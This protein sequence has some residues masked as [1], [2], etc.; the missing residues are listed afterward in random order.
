MLVV[1][2]RS[3]QSASSADASDT[4]L[5]PRFCLGECCEQKCACCILYWRP[6]EK[7]N[8]QREAEALREVLRSGSLLRTPILAGSASLS[9]GLLAG[10]SEWRCGLSWE[11]TDLKKEAGLG[12]VG[13]S[14]TVVICNV[15]V[16]VN[17]GQP[18]YYVD[19]YKA[20]ENGDAVQLR[21]R[22]DR[23]FE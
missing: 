2:V 5:A 15:I 18:G 9:E 8:W 7:V 20:V 13:G 19:N 22:T 12:L 1:V 21:T 16:K 4:R 6:S 3:E 17:L 11:I 14:F 10:A 23:F